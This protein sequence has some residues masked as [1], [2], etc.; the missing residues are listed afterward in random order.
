MTI[1][2]VLFPVIQAIIFLP[3]KRLGGFF[4]HKILVNAYRYYFIFKNHILKN[5]PAVPSNRWTKIINNRQTIHLSIFIIA[6]ITIFTS[7]SKTQAENYV[8]NTLLISLVQP[9]FT[10][11]ELIIETAESASNGETKNI[12]IKYTQNGYIQASKSILVFLS[13]EEILKEQFTGAIAAGGTAIIKQDIATTD[14]DRRRR[15]KP[16]EHIVQAGDT[17]TGIARKYDVS[18]NTILWENSLSA[19]S[20]IRPDKKL[21]I[22]PSSGLTHKVKKNDTI[23]KLAKTYQVETE[24]ILEANNLLDGTVLKIEQVVFVPE[25]LKPKPTPSIRYYQPPTS[26]FVAAPQDGSFIWPTNGYRI[27]QYFTW[28]HFGLD[29]GN[30]SGQPIYAA[31]DGEVTISSQGRW[32]GGYG[33]QVVIEH[34]N[35]I[36]TRYAHNSYN[37]VSVGQKITQG[38]PIAAIG[39]TGRSSGSH[40][41]FEIMVNSRRV[42]PL[43]Y[44]GR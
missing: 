35:G 28:R 22:L 34:G 2:R 5:T 40:L 26:G 1:A 9:E 15:T 23:E 21:I 24:A 17:V 38:Q 18:V 39:S 8:E 13:E 29:I 11:E 3:I 43:N 20:I 31:A 25:G 7:V 36:K 30:R 14:I 6:L 41:H 32:N 33:T 12:P 27:T 19:Y 42:N 37:L 4:F 10:E 16:E 44:I